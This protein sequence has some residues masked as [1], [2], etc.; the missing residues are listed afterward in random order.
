MSHALEKY[1]LYYFFEKESIFYLMQKKNGSYEMKTSLS[2]ALYF[3]SKLCLGILKF[4]FVFSH[5]SLLFWFAKLIPV[6]HDQNSSWSNTK[7]LNIIRLL[8]KILV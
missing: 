5:S 7:V 8:V 2:G 3:P 1:E 6:W 4:S